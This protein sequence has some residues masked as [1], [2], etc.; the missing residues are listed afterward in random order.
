MGGGNWGDL[1]HQGVMG[2]E[3]G[4]VPLSTY[5]VIDITCLLASCNNLSHNILLFRYG[6]KGRAEKGFMTRDFYGNQYL[7]YLIREL[8]KL[9]LLQIRDKSSTTANGCV[10]DVQFDK[11]L[12]M[13]CFEVG[14]VRRSEVFV[15]VDN[16]HTL[17]LFTGKEKVETHHPCYK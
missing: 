12:D 7:G 3:G 16:T 8:G 4:A 15:L 6:V 2:L 11:V 1:E 10:F 9:R 14:C 13:D 5:I 17:H